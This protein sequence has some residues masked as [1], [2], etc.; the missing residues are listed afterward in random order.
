MIETDIDTFLQTLGGL[1]GAS[2]HTVKAYAE[3]LNQFADYTETNGVAKIEDIDVR[4]LR[5]YLQH[6]HQRDL[7]RASR[8]R[9]TATL[10]SF[11]SYLVKQGRIPQ[12]PAA[13]LRTVKR[14]QRLPKF[15]RDEEIEALMA[16]PD[17]SPLGLRDRALLETLYASG[18]RAAELAGI[19]IRDVDFAE[20]CIR[21]I[22]KGNKERVTLIGH[23]AEEALQRYLKLG[24][25]VLVAAVADDD[26]ALFVNRYGKRLSDRGVR[27]LFDRY[28]AAA[29]ATLKITPHVLRH[30][31]ATH[32]LSNGADLRLVQELLG[33][34][35]LAT[36]QLY[37][38]VTTERLQ[39]VH[40]K[41]HP[42]AGAA[43]DY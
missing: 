28:C 22:G 11:F 5:N 10:R 27:K 36:T 41:A 37:T 1:R 39:E 33:H 34:A 21:V 9:K 3:D 16:A 40:R 2:Q 23:A 26:R 31:F 8:A 19:A 29:S 38:H 43:A 17:Q 4:F 7:A 24:R 42:R 18:M 32:L 20:G 35:S 25:P 15:L 30:T 14:E 13:G 6:L 12:S